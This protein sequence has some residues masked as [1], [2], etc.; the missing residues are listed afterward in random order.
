MLYMIITCSD[1][2]LNDYNKVSRKYFDTIFLGREDD[3]EHIRTLNHLLCLQIE[4]MV[5]AQ[6]SLKKTWPAKGSNIDEI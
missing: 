6:L 5:V 4:F 1:G 3:D 2:V